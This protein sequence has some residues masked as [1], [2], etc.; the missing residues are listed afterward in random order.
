M[1]KDG[2]AHTSFRGSSLFQ[3]YSGILHGG[4]VATLLDATMTHCLFHHGVRAVTGDINV[5]FLKP[6]PFNSDLNLRAW[7][8]LSHSLLYKLESELTCGRTQLAR[9][10]ARFMKKKDQ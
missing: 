2:S 4:I 8:T 10:K 3:G 6:I 9:G 7:I 5:R 1:A